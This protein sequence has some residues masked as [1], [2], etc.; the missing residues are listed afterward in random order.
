MG[1]KA[2]GRLRSGAAR[3]GGEKKFQLLRG[4]SRIRGPVL[5]D[6]IESV[7]GLRFEVDSE[8]MLTTITACELRSRVLI[9]F[10]PI[11]EDA[12]WEDAIERQGSPTQGNTRTSLMEIPQ[13][14][15]PRKMITSLLSSVIAVALH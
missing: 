12:S 5:S 8:T 13:E 1:E 15:I 6:R 3:R 10:F 2:L 14:I 7:G 9:D 4:K 11:A